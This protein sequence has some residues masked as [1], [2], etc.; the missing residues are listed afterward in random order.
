MQKYE[1]YHNDE[2]KNRRQAVETDAN[3]SQTSECQ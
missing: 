2:K 1:K 3:P